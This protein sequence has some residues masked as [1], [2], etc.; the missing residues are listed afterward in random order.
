MSLADL[1]RRIQEYAE[2]EGIPYSDND[3]PQRNA[4]VAEEA[5]APAAWDSNEDFSWLTVVEMKAKSREIGG[6]REETSR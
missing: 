5:P 3:V 1:H 4:P 6:F 2:K